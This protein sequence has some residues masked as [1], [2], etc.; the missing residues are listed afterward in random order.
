MK[1]PFRFGSVALAV[2]VSCTTVIG[3]GSKGSQPQ[4]NTESI[5][6][7]AKAQ[8]NE[9]KSMV[10]DILHTKEGLDTLKDIV[11][12]P[13]FKQSLAINETDVQ[14]AMVKAMTDG[15]GN[16]TLLAQMRNPQFA[17]TLAKAY[18]KD[19]EVILKELMKDPEYQQM[20]FA[21]LKS[22]DY[23]KTLYDL[24][25][26]PQY[27]KQTMDIMTQSLQN[28]QFKLL[29]LDIVKEAIHQ[30]TE[31]R[32]P[33][34]KK[35]AGQTSTTMEEGGQEGGQDKEKEKK[36]QEKDKEKK[37]DESSGDKKES[38]GSEEGGDGGNK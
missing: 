3:C 27:R 20:M 18:K 6:V 34:Q 11:R 14:N 25:K 8:Y 23:Q 4:A 9:T 5:N 7:E 36:D 17:S 24:M 22:P 28:P 35:Q 30:G 26:T 37:Q 19:N 33:N 32:T 21:L 16:A 2:I 15:A 10:L 12:D 13:Q 31:E 38:G 1:R 29:F